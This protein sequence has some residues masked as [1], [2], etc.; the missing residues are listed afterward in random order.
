[1]PDRNTYWIRLYTVERS[2]KNY[3]VYGYSVSAMDEISDWKKSNVSVP[4]SAWKLKQYNRFADETEIDRLRSEAVKGS[5]TVI[6]EGNEVLLETVAL[7]A[8]PPVLA[9]PQES[10]ARQ[11][12]KSFSGDLAELEAFWTLDKVALFETIFPEN[13][14]G[15]DGK[16][17][18]IGNLLE[19]LRDRVGIAF[20]GNESG[21][22]GNFEIAR[23]F[24]GD[25]RRPDGLSCHVERANDGTMSLMVWIERPLQEMADLLIGCRLFNG[26]TRELQT[27]IL[28]EIR[29]CEVGKKLFFTPKE[30]IS[31]FAVSVWSSGKLVACQSFG[32]LRALSFGLHVS[33]SGNRVETGWSRSLPENLRQKA[34]SMPSGRTERSMIGEGTSDPWRSS[35]R[36]SEQFTLSGF[37]GET[38]GKFFTKGPESEVEAANFLVTLFLRSEVRKV[39]IA[40]PFFDT[41]GLESVLIKLGGLKELVVISSHTAPTGGK[42]QLASTCE[43]YRNRLPTN[44]VFLNLEAGEEK[45][46]QFHDRYVRIEMESGSKK[47]TEVWMLSNSLSSFAKYYPL[48]LVLVPPDVAKEISEYLTGLEIGQVDGRNAKPTVIWSKDNSSGLKQTQALLPISRRQGEFEGSSEILKSLAEQQGLL[49][50]DWRV[51]AGAISTVTAAM[52]SALAEGSRRNSQLAA[53]ARWA[54]N[55]GPDANEYRF[56]PSEARWIA[57]ALDS[58][59]RSPLGAEVQLRNPL[60]VEAQAFHVC[61]DQVFRFVDSPP[62]FIRTAASAEIEFYANSLWSV[63]PEILID[64]AVRTRNEHLYCW[65]VSNLRA[66]DSKKVEILIKASL[67]AIRALGVA[68]IRQDEMFRR[69]PANRTIAEKVQEEIDV[70]LGIPKEVRK[71]LEEAGLASNE[72]LLSVVYLEARNHVPKLQKTANFSES[73]SLWLENSPELE[74]AIVTHI[75]NDAA[76]LR[77][78]ELVEKLASALTAHPG[79]NGLLEW[80]IEQILSELPLRNSVERQVGLKIWRRAETLQPAASAVWKIKGSETGA[81]YIET[82]LGDLKYSLVVEPLLQRRNYSAWAEGIDSILFALE[83]GTTLFQSAPDELSA[84]EFRNA[85]FSEI[86]SALLRLG[87][88]LWHHSEQPA[89]RLRTVVEVL[90]RACPV[91]DERMKKCCGTLIEASSIPDIWKLWLAAQ[92]PMLVLKYSSILL[93]ISGSPSSGGSH[94]FSGELDDWSSAILAKFEQAEESVIPEN[95]DNSRSEDFPRTIRTLRENLTRWRESFQ[96]P[97]N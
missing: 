67:P 96:M 84:S 88:E 22:F 1:M 75:I 90:G 9:I 54:W 6:V 56:D 43:K 82:V 74:T 69:R 46:Q 32:I 34:E 45:S 63:A 64:M 27:C 23:Y 73:A 85:T 76:P 18:A 93:Q 40:D 83:L 42:F 70:N 47:P 71:R 31:S 25:F 91:D 78:I 57:D 89:Y 8:R 30:P 94:R 49:S 10:I 44:C 92:S 37:S 33:D 48:T 72:I 80:C 39:T 14:F 26:G 87:P 17:Y 15:A 24:S 11:S 79:Q 36:D 5:F 65:L 95:S 52:K 21:R 51:D 13:V 4:G 19:T 28:D 66:D 53:L 20:D 12:P 97:R 81:W 2:G 55:G 61:L 60:L 68:L 86:A 59:L 77:A 38:R 41:I 16:K 62:K 29:S 35:E 3:F 50:A 58:L 7:T